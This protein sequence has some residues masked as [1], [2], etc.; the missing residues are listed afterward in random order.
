MNLKSS[1]EKIQNLQEDLLLLENDNK[2]LKEIE[3]YA[4]KLKA[5]FEHFKQIAQKDKKRAYDN[6]TIDLFD[7]MIPVL[8][9]FERAMMYM[10]IDNANKET[11]MI[12]KGIQMIYQ[13]FIMTLESEG[14]T[15]IKCTP[16]TVYDPFEQEISEQI[17]DDSC[18]EHTVLEVVE[19]GFKFK[20]TVL[21]PARVKVSVKK[22]NTESE[23]TE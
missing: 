18:E 13:S 7:K 3:E 4:F 22:N 20:Q 14:L 10:K 15:E 17:E 5:D 9:N 23:R 12:V 1:I 21:K 2:R 8:T 6:A 19:K 16:G 11:Q